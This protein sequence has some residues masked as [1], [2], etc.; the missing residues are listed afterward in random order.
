M[1]KLVAGAIAVGGNEQQV[2]DLLHHIS[3]FEVAGSQPFVVAEPDYDTSTSSH[4]AIWTVAVNLL[5]RG[6]PTRAP[7]SL[8][9]AILAENWPEAT[10]LLDNKSGV[11]FERIDKNKEGSLKFP[12]VDVPDSISWAALLWRALHPLDTRLRP[13]P[14]LHQQLAT[15]KTGTVSEAEIEF[16]AALL[17]RYGG[18]HYLP[19][20]LDSQTSLEDLL[21]RDVTEEG[22]LHKNNVAKPGDFAEQDADFTLA[23]PYVWKPGPEASVPVGNVPA[24]PKTVLGAITV[25]GVILE[26]D[27]PHHKVPPQVQKDTAR[28]K[29]ARDVGW[30]PVRLPTNEFEQPKERLATLRQLL[31]A[32]PYFAR[33]QANYDDSL[34]ESAEGRKALQL[35]LGPLAVARVQRTLLEAL[36]NGTISPAATHIE[37]AVVERDL[38]C[39]QQGIAAL[40]EQLRRLYALEG[41]GRTVPVVVLT[42]YPTGEFEQ[43]AHFNHAETQVKPAGSVPSGADKFALVLDVSVLQRPGFSKAVDLPGVQCLTIRTAAMPKEA[44]RFRSAPLIAYPPLVEYDPAHETYKFLDVNQASRAQVLEELVQDLFR[45]RGLREGQLPIISRGLQGLSVLG[46][47]PTGGGKSLT[48]QMAVLLQPGIALVVDPIKSLMQDQFEGLQRNWID[49]VTYLNSSVPGRPRKELRLARMQAGEV[50]FMFV[51]PERLVIKEDFRDRLEAM[52]KALPRVGFS[53]CVIDEAHCV[54]EWGHNFR[55]PYLRLGANARRFCH[56]YTGKEV[57][58]YGLT[59]TASFDVLADV[60][61][62]LDIDKDQ[63]AVIRTATMARPELHVRIVAADE[64][65]KERNAVGKAKHE[66]LEQVLAEVPGALLALNGKASMDPLPEK[67]KPPV[68]L[69]A[70][71]TENFFEAN[72]STGKLEQAGLVFCPHTK[73]V[74]GVP[75]IFRLLTAP[76]RPGP[77]LKAG[78]FMGTDDGDSR[79]TQAAKQVSMGEM[80][81]GFVEGDSNILVATKAFGMGIDK[82]NVRF[83]VHYG[84]P[85]SI[86]SFVQEAGRAGRDRAVALNYILY[87][88]TDAETQEFFFNKTFKAREQ[89]VRVM[90]ELLTRITFPSGECGA[91]NAVLEEQFPDLEVWARLHRD[92]GAATPKTL[93]LNGSDGLSYGR[94]TLSKLPNLEGYEE[95]EKPAG[96]PSV[97]REVVSFAMNYLLQLPTEAR[98]SAALLGNALGGG[99]APGSID[100]ILLRWKAIQAGAPNEGF[101]IGFRNGTLREMSEAATLAGVELSEKWLLGCCQGAA[102]GRAFAGTVGEKFWKDTGLDLPEELGRVLKKKFAGVRLEQ[103]TFRAI[104]RLCLLGVIADYTIDYS[105]SSVRVVLAPPQGLDL[106]ATYQDYLARYTTP[107]N[108][109]DQAAAVAGREK[110]SSLLEKY[111]GALLDF[112]EREIKEKR[113]RGIAAMRDAC[114]MGMNPKENLSNYF[115]LYFNSKYARTEYLPTDTKEGR[116]YNEAVVWKYLN[117]M[118]TPPDGRGQERDNIKHLRG[119]CARLLSAQPGNGAFLL[120]SSRT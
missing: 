95:D 10:D 113:R 111:V 4:Q 100:G 47:L 97:L 54:S 11:N 3:W 72:A 75:E 51:S 85:D 110:G 25:R 53:Y 41:K 79:A 65:L 94:I 13:G 55:T 39:G 46:L 49:A 78:F 115:D 101:E 61:R 90:H 26:I 45:K 91:L 96:P 74:I 40:L 24:W 15:W 67:A 92:K 33:L 105:A 8:A 68:Q 118:T 5:M 19:Q 102:D 28:D 86:E 80:Q 63:A 32:H 43:P 117:F 106:Q 30:W 37:L 109:R 114:L 56:T 27:G 119:A 6:L 14:S 36:L 62:E 58:L 93:Y 69:G 82:P 35:V 73:G 81:T 116:V 71:T 70:W 120:L 17:P 52:E 60:Q 1:P 89:E 104:H 98:L 103:D 38:P 20:L 22:Q 107:D 83:T 7:L 66:L 57:P 29:A 112:N 50:L 99:V 48:Y 2:R 108:A 9:A 88:E 59:A 21:C 44:R 23:F 18:A 64:K 87:H 77:L 12:L 34:L 31:K 76:G 16:A 84:Y 42:I